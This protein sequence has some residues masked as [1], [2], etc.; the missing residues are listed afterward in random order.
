MAIQHAGTLA[1]LSMF[2]NYDAV[3]ASTRKENY[4]FSLLRGTLLGSET[5]Y[6]E[7][8]FSVSISIVFTHAWWLT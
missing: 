7:E 5:V 8:L 2:K 6:K 3:H 4:V 1:A